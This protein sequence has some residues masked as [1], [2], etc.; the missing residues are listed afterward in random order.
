M[1]C[2]VTLQG[3]CQEITI[4]CEG[5]NILIST[6]CVCADGFQ[7]L[8]KAFHYP[9]QLLT[10]Y[11]LLWNY[12]LILKMLTDPPAYWNSPQ[13]FLLCD[14]SMFSSA[15][16]SLAAGTINVKELTCHKRIP[17]W[18]YRITVGGFLYAFWVS[19][20]SLRSL[21]RITG[22]IFKNSKQFQRRKL[23]L[24]FFHQL[25]SKKL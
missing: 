2:K 19:K 14:W 20:S 16:L 1:F 17:I 3:Q 4:C 23:K 21:K 24:L 5:L 18:F 10:F 11:L 22:R 12:L 15:D 25:R 6:F 8:S 9:I 13:N 7:G